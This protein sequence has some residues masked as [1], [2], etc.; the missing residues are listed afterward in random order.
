[1][2]RAELL[3]CP[4]CDLLQSDSAVPR[5]RKALCARCGATLYQRHDNGLD[6]TAALTLAALVLFVL[7]NSFPILS[8]ELQGERTTATLSGAVETLG[9]HGM[10]AL[11]ALVLVTAIAV[12][13]AQLAGLVYLVLPVRYG[14][15]VP[16]FGPVFRLV[17]L[18]T[19]WAMVDVFVLAI[20]VAYVRLD[21]VAD[22][23]AGLASWAFAALMLVMAAIKA[24]FDPRELWELTHAEPAA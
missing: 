10:P 11:A 6:R 17:M 19:H 5:P 24:N 16:A 22:V 15:R 18:A 12:P 20:L 14:Y 23:S 2:N 13:L 1:M 8:L 7:A 3:A 9:S 21:S 4:E